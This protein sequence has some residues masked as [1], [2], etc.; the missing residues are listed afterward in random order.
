MGC[1]LA[2]VSIF[3][4]TAY[5][6]KMQ[7]LF[8]LITLLVGLLSIAKAGSRSPLVVLA[9]VTFFFFVARMG[10]IKALF[11]TLVSAVL[12]IVFLHSIEA[13]LNSIGSSLTA[14]VESA[15][16]DNESSGRNDI[17]S[18]ALNIIK[19]SPITGKYYIIPYG[20]GVG[21][22]PHNF[23]LEVFMATG[24]LGGI[25][26]VALIFIGLYRSFRLLKAQHPSS[27][28]VLLFL[29]MI[30]FGS[31][32]TGLYSSQDL[33][34]LLFFVCS[35]NMYNLKESKKFLIEQRGNSSHVFA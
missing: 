21:G 20:E 27:W 16:N 7:K 14:R 3:G 6:K 33:W 19:S 35:I 23:F 29:Q 32:S 31:F 25:P 26:F 12:F 30:V 34:A 28:I 10:F 2:I 24:L 5:Q 11:I 17:W 15:V 1:A 9:L 13:L 22:Y 4:I 8:F 18:N